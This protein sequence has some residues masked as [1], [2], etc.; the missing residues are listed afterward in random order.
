[1]ALLPSSAQSFE[2]CIGTSSEALCPILEDWVQRQAAPL[3][4]IIAKTERMAEQCNISYHI[5][6]QE[7]LLKKNPKRHPRKGKSCSCLGGGKGMASFLLF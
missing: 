2:R 5:L 4:V 3:C 1:M 6:R 7:E